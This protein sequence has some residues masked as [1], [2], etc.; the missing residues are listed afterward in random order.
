MLGKKVC[1]TLIEK[2]IHEF[3]Y[4]ILRSRSKTLESLP[5]EKKKIVMKMLDWYQEIQK[6]I[7][8]TDYTGR[9][10]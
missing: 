5:I 10:E 4:I 8:D 2:H 1:S 7:F 3:G 6:E 9:V